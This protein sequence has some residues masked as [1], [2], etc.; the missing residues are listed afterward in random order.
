MAGL[1]T[2]TLY[3]NSGDPGTMSVNVRAATSANWNAIQA[4][5]VAFETAIAGLSDGAIGQRKFTADNLLF[6]WTAPASPM[7][8]RNI[9]FTVSYRDTT[10]GK[11][12][13]VQIP[14]ADLDQ[15]PTGTEEVPIDAGAGL[16]FVTAFEAL[17][18]SPAGN[19]VNVVQIT[20]ND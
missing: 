15:L 2:V 16:A 17:A 12:Y 11:N 8:Q 10:T 1:Y 4:D 13:Y 14:C 7:V 3:D 19:P 6:P 20:Y 18:V 5:I 9:K